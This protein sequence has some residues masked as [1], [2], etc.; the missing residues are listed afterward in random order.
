MKKYIVAL[1]SGG[2]QEDPNLKYSE[3]EIIEA[4]DAN[5]AQKKYNTMKK[6][7]FFEGMTIGEVIDNIVI[8][9]P[10]CKKMV[11]SENIDAKLYAKIDE[12]Y[13]SSE[14]YQ[15]WFTDLNVIYDN[16]SKTQE[17]LEDGYILVGVYNSSDGNLQIDIENIAIIDCIANYVNKNKQKVL[18]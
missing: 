16:D 10:W 7:N 5:E 8:L 3:Y 13:S 2:L 18:V 6:C 15:S 4:N 11:I 1:E 9:C 14:N 12:D 17:M